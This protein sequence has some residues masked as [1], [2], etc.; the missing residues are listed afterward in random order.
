MTSALEAIRRAKEGAVRAQHGID[1]D[2][3]ARAEMGMES[4]DGSECSQSPTPSMDPVRV[5]GTQLGCVQFR[6][7]DL[8]PTKRLAGCGPTDHDDRHLRAQ[9]FAQRARSGR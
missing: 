2:A 4:D 5:R 1:R 3:S 8:A 7:R 9:I 6:S